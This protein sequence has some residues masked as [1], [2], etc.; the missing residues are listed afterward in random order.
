[1]AGPGNIARNIGQ[2]GVNPPDNAMRFA[3]QSHRIALPLRYPA[4]GI[5]AGARGISE[6]GGPGVGTNHR[7]RGALIHLL[8][9]LDPP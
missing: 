7:R 6:A 1:M 3:P 5:A 8:W 2:P 9:R 4:L